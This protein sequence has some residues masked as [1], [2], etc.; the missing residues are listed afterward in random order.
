[1]NELVFEVTRETDGDFV[2]E[3]FGK[4]LFTEANTWDAL[5]PNVRE[6]VK[7]FTLTGLHSR[8][9]IHA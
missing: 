2:P 8:I 6:A 9:Q 1:M 3:A 4:S 5:R 7:H